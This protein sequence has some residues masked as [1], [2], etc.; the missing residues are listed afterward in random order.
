MIAYEAPM[1]AG[2]DRVSRPYKI[3]LRLAEGNVPHII[4]RS[5]SKM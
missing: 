5:Q 2:F 4:Q 3:H 1:I